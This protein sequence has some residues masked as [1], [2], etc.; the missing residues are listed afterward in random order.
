[1][2][3]SRVLTT[4]KWPWTAAVYRGVTLVGPT[5]NASSE[6]RVS[7]SFKTSKKSNEKNAYEN[8]EV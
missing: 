3:S 2:D 7:S 4:P 5:V 8:V 1:M 6:E